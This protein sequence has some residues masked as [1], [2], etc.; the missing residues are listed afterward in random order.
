MYKI[1]IN[2]HSYCLFLYVP[3][4]KKAVSELKIHMRELVYGFEW[5]D[6]RVLC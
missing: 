5:F 3:K 1:G 6:W 4:A 2:E